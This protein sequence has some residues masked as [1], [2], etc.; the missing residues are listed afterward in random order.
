VSGCDTLAAGFRL[1]CLFV[2]EDGGDMFLGNIC[3]I[4][5]DYTVISQ[6]IEFFATIAKRTCNP[7]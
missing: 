1:G 5:M 7:A 6:K 3:L 4:P 2:P